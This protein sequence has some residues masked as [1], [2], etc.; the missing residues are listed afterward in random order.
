MAPSGAGSGGSSGA[1]LAAAGA[2]APGAPR[3][4]AG[5]LKAPPASAAAAARG[6]SALAGTRGRAALR[7]LQ[8]AAGSSRSGAAAAGEASAAY[9]SRNFDNGSAINGR[10]AAALGG[11]GE[12]QAPK[13]KKG[14]DGGSPINAD[15]GGMP[16][17]LEPGHKDATPWGALV[18]AATF[19]LLGAGLL[20]LTAGLLAGHAKKLL[21]AAAADPNPVTKAAS[22]AAAAHFHTAAE[23]TAGVAGLAGL[24]AVG[25]GAKIYA[26][27]AQTQ[28]LMMIAGGAI[29]SVLAVKTLVEEHDAQAEVAKA[30]DANKPDLEAKLAEQKAEAG[31]LSMDDALHDDP[32]HHMTSMQEQ[33]MACQESP[34]DRL[35]DTA[36]AP[37]QPLQSTLPSPQTAQAGGPPP[38]MHEVSPDQIDWSKVRNRGLKPPGS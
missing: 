31:K 1:S 19:L 22:L 17:V 4:D 23:W 12:G 5:A 21:A 34:V 11:A 27:G 30:V 2:A 8:L 33:P 24:A 16:Q 18:A 35:I 7:Q 20:L 26:M 38:G 29:V 13:E 32:V 10:G 36:H 6:G 14:Y 3:A 37:P 15:G 25:L 9:A 28:A